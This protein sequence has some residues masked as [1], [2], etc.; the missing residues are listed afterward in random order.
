MTG[1]PSLGD[2]LAALEQ[3]DSVVAKAAASLARIHESMQARGDVPRVR[4]RKSTP[5]RPCQAL[6]IGTDNPSE[7]SR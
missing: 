2:D 5:D 4:F 7:A 6:P 3:A 1:R